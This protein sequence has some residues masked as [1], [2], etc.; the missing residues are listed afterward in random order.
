MPS[1]CPGSK[2]RKLW[3]TRQC[4][5]SRT[6]KGRARRF[7]LKGG[8]K[9]N[10]Q[11]SWKSNPGRSD[12]ERH[13]RTPY[14]IFPR[15]KPSSWFVLWRCAVAYTRGHR[16]RALTVYHRSARSPLPSPPSDSPR[17]PPSG[18]PG[19]PPSTNTFSFSW[20]GGG[21]RLRLEQRFRE[22]VCEDTADWSRVRG[23]ELPFIFLI[24]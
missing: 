11:L 1:R 9:A 5:H 8:Y 13:D 16:P 7:H 22:D 6:R 15:V 10:N 4:H 23:A 18:E 20:G 21:Q 24:G 14:P 17:I 12:V 19:A 2:Q 3:R